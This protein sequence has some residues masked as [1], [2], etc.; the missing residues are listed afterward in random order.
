[1][2]F[3]YNTA[4]L[5]WLLHIT[6]LQVPLAWQFGEQSWGDCPLPRETRFR[7][8]YI[9]ALSVSWCKSSCPQSVMLRRSSSLCWF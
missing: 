3:I 7:R 2:S 9:V 1:M 6:L 4:E 5:H 8:N